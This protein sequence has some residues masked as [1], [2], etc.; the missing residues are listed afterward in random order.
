LHRSGA[1]LAWVCLVSCECGG[2][3]ESSDAAPQADREHTFEAGLD[4]PGDSKDAGTA[5]AGQDSGPSG[6][7]PAGETSIPLRIVPHEAEP[8][9]CG[10][11]CRQVTWGGLGGTYDLDG[12]WLAYFGSELGLVDMETG[13]EFTAAVL[14]PEERFPGARSGLAIASGRAFYGVRDALAD[15]G[16]LYRYDLGTQCARRLLTFANSPAY[17]DANPA[18]VTWAVGVEPGRQ[19]SFSFDL[20][21]EEQISLTTAGC[22]VGQ[23]RV[24]ED[25][26]VMQ[27]WAGTP[28]TIAA[29]PIAGGEVRRLW[30]D[31]R[32]QREPA[33]HENRV[34]FTRQADWTDPPYSDIYAVDLLS[35]A[36]FIVSDAPSSQGWPD[37]HG[38][39]VAWE[40]DRDA[41][42]HDGIPSIYAVDIVSGKETRVTSLP[43]GR[44]RIWGRTV[45]FESPVGELVQILALDVPE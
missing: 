38:D 40:D 34:V 15:E 26:V 3:A 1:L 8:F 29:I 35:G 14:G 16:R 24:W 21:H 19:D 43:G 20:A 28:R 17:I 13:D 27:Y 42:Q 2:Q 45:F 4:E 36:N 11:G 41:E 5:D 7:C 6:N 9:D 31:P 32:E 18:F 25:L 12:S 33:I 39:L 44:P 23:N 10:E 37:I 30:D 22:C